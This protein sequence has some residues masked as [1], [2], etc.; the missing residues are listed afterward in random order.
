MSS[1]TR[2]SAQSQGQSGA[3][4]DSENRDRVGGH[5]GRQDAHGGSVQV[6]GPV[7]QNPAPG[8]ALPECFQSTQALH[9]VQEVG[10]QGAVSLPPS[11]AGVPVP[12]VEEIGYDQ[13]EQRESQEYE[14]DPE[15]DDG[16][17]GKDDHR[18]QR[19]HDELRQVLAKEG[20]QLVDA[21]GHGHQHVAGAGLVEVARPQRQRVV[22]E[23]LS[24]L[25]FDD[26]GRMV[27]DH[28][29]DVLQQ[30]AQHD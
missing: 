8:P 25:D 27:A 15:I 7:G 30:A 13:S 10:A 22:V 9:R 21:L 5:V 24:E 6:P 12:A 23:P 1:L 19:R 16:H 14:G 11:H 4:G 26:A 29:L 3:R 2:E 18:R 17:E 20:L 28:L